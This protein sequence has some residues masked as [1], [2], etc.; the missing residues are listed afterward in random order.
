MYK[1]KL[2]KIWNLIDKIKNDINLPIISDFLEW[3][4]DK[5]ELNFNKKTPKLIFNK[6][7]IYFINLWKNIW[8]ELNKTRPCLIISKTYFNNSNTLII[9]PLKS[10][11]WKKNKNTQIL[12]KHKLLKNS[13]VIDFLSIRQIDKKRINNYVWTISKKDIEKINKKL[14][15]IFWLKNNKE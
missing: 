14:I 11:K 13:S 9:A 10:Y 7:D 15:K 3:F 6:W 4:Y 12:L 8:S 2:N 1:T 5:I